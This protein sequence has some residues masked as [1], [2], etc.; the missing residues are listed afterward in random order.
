MATKVKSDIS[1]EMIENIKNYGDEIQELKDF[2][3]SVRYRPGMYIGGIG[4]P[5]FI[6]M[7]RE[8][9]QN[10]LDE[11]NKESSPCDTVSITYDERSFTTIV[12]DNGRGIPFGRMIQIFKN[13]HT[14]SNF[15]KKKGEYSSGLHGVGS[16]V[17]NALSKKFIVESY[18][19][20]EARKVEFNDGY[21][22]NKGEVPIKKKD[23]DMQQGTRVT[24]QPALEVLGKLET[25]WKDVYNLI[26]LIL[27]LNKLGAVIN[28][29]GIDSEGKIH[30]EKFIN[31]DGIL[32]YIIDDT[33][34]PLVKP[35]SIFN[36]TG[37]MRV[38]ILFTYDMSE[39]SV[40]SLH[41]FSNFCPTAAGTHIDGFYDG[42]AAFFTNYMNKK[43]LAT[44]DKTKTKKAKV[45]VNAADTRAGLCA[46][47]SAAHL[48]PIFAGQSKERL[49]N[50]EMRPFV[51]ATVMDALE[52]WSKDSPSEF[53]KVC[54]YL[55]EMAELR[56][57][58]D[59][60]RVKITSK[61]NSSSLTGLPSTF[62]APTGKTDLELWICEG[63]SALGAMRNNRINSKQGLFP[64]RGK[65]PN[66]F[67]WKRESFLKN[68][69]VAGIIAI[70]FDKYPG[71]DINKLGRKSFK[72]DVS[73]IKW[74]KIIFGTDADSDG[75]HIDILL[76]SLFIL[77][78]PEL[79][80]AG[81]IYEAQPPL[82]GIK[83]SGNKMSY[84]NTRADYV[85]YVQKKFSAKYKIA[86][87]KG[88]I[89]T[90]KELSKLL[91]QNIDYTYEINR[92]S[93]TYSIDPVLLESILTLRNKPFADFKKSIKK[94]YRFLD[95]KKVGDTVIITGAAAGN[96]QTVYF[97]DKL[98][99]LCK[100]IINI[101]DSNRYMVYNVNGTNMSL[102]EFMVLFDEMKPTVERYKGL[103]EMGPRI[104][105]AAMDPESRV[106]VQYSMQDAVKVVENMRY[107]QNNIYQL[108]SDIQVSRFDLMD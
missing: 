62:V 108:I 80:E 70:I 49:S 94:A 33:T 104:F 3:T 34:S 79:V 30:S 37:E 42:I 21:P 69:E 46:V 24:F 74:K 55:K 6:N 84:L 11:L 90:H 88:K 77:Y 66:A 32:G 96:V 75:K 76:L 91:Y 14:S 106:L 23:M 40:S 51:K 73:K 56:I 20:G 93:G 26:K 35:I 28:F 61:F 25:T 31:K 98:I 95:C 13:Q 41:A 27:P 81:M 22:W 54:K 47:V 4:D 102:Y 15:T 38:E 18:I 12:E 99:S 10:S 52:K 85:E 97:N 59:S 53:L 16:K 9:V 57:K 71:F 100:E 68:E 87:I 60:D 36:D 29:T 39:N 67:K 1:K 2:I 101:I 89:L 44:A 7:I 19:L 48:E 45:V 50:E 17:T 107:Y 105:D 82:Y 64:I 58:G 72:I 63:K 8:I 92:I 83:K 65:I 103:G 5:G 43:Y 78:M 86:D